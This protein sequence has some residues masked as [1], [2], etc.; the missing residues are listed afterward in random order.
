MLIVICKRH[1]ENNSKIYSE[2]N[3]GIKMAHLKIAYIKQKK[4]VIDD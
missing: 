2:R 3:K 1:W 4:A